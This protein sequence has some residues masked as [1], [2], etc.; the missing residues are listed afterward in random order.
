MVV[1]L[2]TGLGSHGD[3]AGDTLSSIENISGSIHDDQLFGAI[4]QTTF[5]VFSATTCSS[6]QPVLIISVE[7]VAMTY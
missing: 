3:A 5:Q 6:G 1:S 2:A 4:L 7:I